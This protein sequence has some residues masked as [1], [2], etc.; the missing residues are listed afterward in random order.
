MATPRR[1]ARG[2]VC[3]G[4]TTSPSTPTI[5]RT[6][7]RTAPVVRGRRE[8]SRGS[9]PSPFS[10]APPTS[11]TTGRRDRAT[12]QT[13]ESP[14]KYDAARDKVASPASNVE[15]F[16]HQGHHHLQAY[17]HPFAASLPH[18]NTPANF[19]IW[20]M[21]PNLGATSSAAVFCLFSRLTG[22]ASVLL[23]ADGRVPV[24]SESVNVDCA[25]AY[26]FNS[27]DRSAAMIASSVIRSALFASSSQGTTR[28]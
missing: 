7:R 4:T 17:F 9:Q 28:R 6:H 18:G 26:G 27:P 23:A 13:A 3:C 15:R 21:S 5:G 2:A 22:S 20:S 24:P 11:E 19:M 14:S 10:P 16:P 12:N 1:T 8:L 25:R